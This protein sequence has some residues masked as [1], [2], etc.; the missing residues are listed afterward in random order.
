MIDDTW[1]KILQECIVYEMLFKA[2]MADKEK[3]SDAQLKLR[4]GPLFEKLSLI[5]EKQHHLYRKEL[6]RLGCKIV[7]RQ[8]QNGQYVVTCRVRGYVEEAVFSG[9]LLKAECEV[10][11]L[12][13]IG[14]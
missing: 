3:I 4:Y 1:R 11:L 13:L 5:A 6:S 10:R 8:N 2:L 7:S 14:Q 9:E 12:T